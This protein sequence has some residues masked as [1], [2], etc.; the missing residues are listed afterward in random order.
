MTTKANFKSATVLVDTLLPT[1][2]SYD[3]TE[4]PGRLAFK[5]L[6]WF[7]NT[8]A[9]SPVLVLDDDPLPP[10]AFA[11]EQHSSPPASLSDTYETL[12]PSTHT[13]TRQ[14]SP[15]PKSPTADIHQSVK[16]LASKVHTMCTQQ[17]DEDYPLS[18]VD[19]R[20]MLME[21][22]N[23]ILETSGAAPIA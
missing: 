17:L 11:L 8:P 21:T 19:F 4:S 5:K 22:V 10:A 9:I 13:E 15:P 3:P 18:P 23:T 16:L 14:Q 6:P 20:E 7:F 12:Q 2:T 1:F